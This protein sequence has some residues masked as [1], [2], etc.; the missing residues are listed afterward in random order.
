MPSVSQAPKPKTL[1]LK[2]KPYSPKFGFCG[3]NSP[4][5]ASPY[6]LYGYLGAFGI[7]GLHSEGQVHEYFLGAI[8]GL[9]RGNGKENGSYDLGCRITGSGGLSK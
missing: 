7:I 5:G 8:E 3:G 2:P 1:K 9:N 6:S 4:S